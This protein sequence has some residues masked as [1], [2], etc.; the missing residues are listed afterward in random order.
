MK[1][2]KNDLKW[3][4]MNIEETRLEEGGFRAGPAPPRGPRAGRGWDDPGGRG[5]FWGPA[6]PHTPLVAL[7]R[8]EKWDPHQAGGSPQCWDLGGGSQGPP[9]VAR[10]T[11]A[12]AKGDPRDP[13]G[14]RL[15]LS[16][17]IRGVCWDLG[18]W[19]LRVC[20]GSCCDSSRP[21]PGP[22]DRPCSAS[23]LPSSPSSRDPRPG[24]PPGALT[25]PPSWKPLPFLLEPR[26]LPLNLHFNH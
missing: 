22:W 13:L 26:P 23:P 9:E 2:G 15:R 8:G 25:P 4:K 5:I 18:G 17:Q 19:A 6:P 11:L 14:V 10:L 20:S 12:L 21:S 7:G 24:A 16:A 3:S 1:T